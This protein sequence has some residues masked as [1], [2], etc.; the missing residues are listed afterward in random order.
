MGSGLIDARYD[1][2]RRLNLRGLVAGSL[3]VGYGKVADSVSP[4][5]YVRDVVAGKRFDSNLTKQ[6]HKGFEV[7]G[8]IPGYSIEEQSLGWGVEIVWKNPDYRR[9]RPFWRPSRYA[10]LYKGA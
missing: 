3:I 5:Q 4:E 10:A 9:S 8:L 2:I 6:L 1:L 7:H